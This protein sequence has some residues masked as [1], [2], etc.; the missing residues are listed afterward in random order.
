[1][2]CSHMMNIRKSLEKQKR[3]KASLR[4]S[5]RLRTTQLSHTK[6]MRWVFFE[7]NLKDFYLLSVVFTCDHLILTLENNHVWKKKLFEDVACY[8][9]GNSGNHILIPTEIHNSVVTVSSSFPSGKI[10]CT[11]NFFNEITDDLHTFLTSVQQNQEL[12]KH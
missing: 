5:G 11:K 7:G 10:W 9:N 2:I 3:G 12:N 1:M 8:Q 6:A 4:D